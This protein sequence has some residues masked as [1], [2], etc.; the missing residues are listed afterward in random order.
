[1]T[2]NFIT[3]DDIEAL[4]ARDARWKAVDLSIKVDEELRE[5]PTVNLILEALARRST[6]AMEKLLDIDPT[7]AGSISALQAQVNCAR[8][9]GTSLESIRQNGLVAQRSLE[10]EGDVDLMGSPNGS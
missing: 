2:E 5:S 8:F 1:M 3:Q 4:K 9:V 7:S 10:E 6:E